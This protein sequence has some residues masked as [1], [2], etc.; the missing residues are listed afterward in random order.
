MDYTYLKELEGTLKEI[1]ESPKVPDKKFYQAL[2]DLIDLK[3]NVEEFNNKFDQ[4]GDVMTAMAR[5]EFNQRVHIP[6][7]RNLFAFIGT[8]IN[9]V[10]DEL[11]RNVV[12]TGFLETLLELEARPTI[13][14]DAKGV[15]LF[16]NK[17]AYTLT[18]YPPKG[19]SRL[20]IKN[21]FIEIIDLGDME[22]SYRKS[23]S[24]SLY[25]KPD[26]I[27]VSLSVQRIYDKQ[28]TVDGYIYFFE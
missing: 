25:N 1:I 18:N 20:I 11:N 5:G 6:I 4:I 21:L 7:S 2:K 16:S 9:S 26:P 24:I 3:L 13:I 12:K 28:G 10:M 17:S 23:V 19:L 8:S 14:T 22:L 27:E 15:I